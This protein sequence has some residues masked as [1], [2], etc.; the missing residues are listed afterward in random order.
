MTTIYGSIAVLSA[1]Y[2]VT[3]SSLKQFIMQIVAMALGTVAVIIISNFDYKNFARLW[4][5]I[6]LVGFSLVI[7]TFFIGY[8]PGNTDDKAWLMLPG[9][10]SFQPSELF[11]GLLYYNL[12]IS[13]LPFGRQGKKIRPHNAALP[14][15]CRSDTAHT[16]SVGRRQRAYFRIYLHRHD[17]CGRR[18][19]KVF[20]NTFLSAAVIASPF[21]YLY[22]MNDDQRSR[23]SAL[24]FG[25][26]TDYQVTLF[27]QWRGRVAMANG[28]VFGQGLFNG[29]LVQ[30]GRIPEGYNDFIFTSIGEELGLIGCLAV[31]ALLAA[32]CIRILKVGF[33]SNNKL[34][35]VMCAGVF[36]MLFSQTV[37]NIGMCLWLI[38][39]IGVTLPFFSAGGTSL[40]CTYLSIGVVMSVYIH[41]DSGITYLREEKDQILKRNIF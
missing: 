39:V 8:A 18:Q 34:G 37:I 35:L 24:F 21:A 3:G 29:P 7:L 9:K 31:I 36:T 25:T 13:L 10:I 19:N 27:Q 26:E 5:V 4:P 14:A 38:P 15:R 32:I 28:G 17:V 1:T 6:Y 12:C 16:V 40:L 23:I 33:L 30:S 20:Y 11:E 2:F 22:V 41:R